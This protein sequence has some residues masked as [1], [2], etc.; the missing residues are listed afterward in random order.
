MKIIRSKIIGF[1]PG[2]S[3]AINNCFPNSI[4][5]GEVIHNKAVIDR[6][7]DSI[8]FIEENKIEDFIKNEN[9]KNKEIIVRAHGISPKLEEILKSRGAL[10]RD[11]TCQNIKKVQNIILQNKSKYKIILIGDRK[12]PEIKGLRE[13]DDNCLVVNFVMEIE[14][15]IKN[16]IKSC[17]EDRL[18]IIGQTTFKKSLYDY[19]C[20]LFIKYK[21]NKKIK[22]IDSLCSETVKRQK[23][24]KK[25]EKKVDAILIIGGHN[26]ANTNQLRSLCSKT[27]WVIE[28][29]N[30]IPSMI[31]LYNTVGLAS[32]ASTP[33]WLVD[34]IENTLKLI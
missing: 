6:L 1:C 24:L 30:Q 15:T 17:P 29:K 8:T 16:I 23:A 12:H 7:K 2:V 20:S 25:L 21:G 27:S 31:K 14:N 33:E 26:S 28:N 34:E 10:I 32:G 22:I 13:Y 11:N 3:N 5:L 4:C 9:Y 18:M 19:F